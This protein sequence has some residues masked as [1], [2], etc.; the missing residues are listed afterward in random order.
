[1]FCMANK[2]K[3]PKT[4]DSHLAK[5]RKGAGLSQKDLANM[6]GTLQANIS[7]WEVNDRMPPAEFL[8]KLAETLGVSVDELLQISSNTRRKKGGPAG[9]AR[10]IFEEVSDLPRGQQEKIIDVVKA[11][12]YQYKVTQK[13]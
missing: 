4:D 7:F 8:P 2:V 5:L 3:P 10:I 13:S 1:M 11:M 9:K 12:I 6:I